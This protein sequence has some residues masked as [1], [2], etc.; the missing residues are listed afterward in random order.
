MWVL[1]SGENMGPPGRMGGRKGQMLRSQ[2]ETDPC[3][4]DTVEGLFM[5]QLT[6]TQRCPNSH[7]GEA[8]W[9]SLK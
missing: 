1:Q 6:Q 7:P 5:G 8:T 3:L 9:P 2:Q 4:Q